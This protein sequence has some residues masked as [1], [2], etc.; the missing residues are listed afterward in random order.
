[1]HAP[2]IASNLIESAPELAK[3]LFMSVRTET[4]P[5]L[6]CKVNDRLYAYRDLRPARNLP[7]HLGELKA[8]LLVCSLGHRFDVKVALARATATAHHPQAESIPS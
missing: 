3:G 5:L 1:M 6:I 8:G 4:D 7:L 2:S